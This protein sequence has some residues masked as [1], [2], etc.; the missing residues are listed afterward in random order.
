MDQIP[1]ND[2]ASLKDHQ[3]ET[4]KVAIKWKTIEVFIV[5]R[6]LEYQFIRK[7]WKTIESWNI[8]KNGPNNYKRCFL[9]ERL[10]RLWITYWK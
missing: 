4:D 3:S 8:K 9:L 2:A 5:K 7:T 10:E 1:M 6:F